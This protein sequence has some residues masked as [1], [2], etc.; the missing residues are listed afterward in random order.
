MNLR[1][2]K[3]VRQQVVASFLFPVQ[4]KLKGHSTL[5]VHREMEANQ[6]LEPQALQ[7]LQLAKLRIFL[8]RVSS[9]V[10]YWRDLFKRQGLRADAFASLEDLQRLP[11]LDKA[12]I[13]EHEQAMKS[14]TATGLS[15]FSTG[16]SSG[17]PLKFFLDN[18]R[19]SHDVAA[20]RRATRW[21]D[22]DI[23]DSEIVVWGSPIELGSQDRVRLLRDRLMR[24]E[25]LSAFEM[26][27]ENLDHFIARIRKRR[28]RMLFGYP[29]SLAAIAAHALERGIAMNDLGIRVAFVTSERLYAHQEKLIT[30]VFGCPVANGYGGRDAGFLAHHCPSRSLHITA[31]DVILEIVDEDGAVLPEGESGEIVVTH[32]HTAAF[33]FIRYR[34]GD[35]GTLDTTRCACGRGLPVLRSLE[36]R[37]TD[38]VVAR[39]GTLLHGLALIYVLRDLPGVA[40]FR[41][42]QE[43]L[44]LTRVQVVPAEGFT[45]DSQREIERQFHARL[46]SEVRIDIEKLAAIPRETSGKFRYVQSKVDRGDLVS[47]GEDTAPGRIGA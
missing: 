19:V 30:D 20:K 23:G 2:N 5:T 24:T 22:V 15:E 43:S 40:A 35:I 46:G 41:I 36:G 28:P 47:N 12:T 37:S 44:D 25:L 45:E 16:G 14:E 38:F 9:E 17:E 7:E 3:S 31:D 26:S 42:V 21:W 6:W 8:A 32:L 4:E 18:E 39:D 13:R 29:S 1:R 33:P 10:P 34:T 27:E 11:L